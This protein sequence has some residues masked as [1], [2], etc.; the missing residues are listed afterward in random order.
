LPRDKEVTTGGDVETVV[1]DYTQSFRPAI[2]QWRKGQGL[3]PDPSVYLMIGSEKKISDLNENVPIYIM[4]TSGLAE[5]ELRSTID[6]L[7]SMASSTC[8]VL[9]V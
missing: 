3:Q 8:A 7:V 6:V 5:K 1:F 2:E 4:V 9:F